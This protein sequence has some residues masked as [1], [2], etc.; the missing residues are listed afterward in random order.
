MIW[1]GSIVFS[2]SRGQDDGRHPAVGYCRRLININRGRPE[3]GAV[4]SLRRL[5]K[6]IEPRRKM[7]L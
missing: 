7:E 3:F 1:R 5:S 2:V 6:K 4:D